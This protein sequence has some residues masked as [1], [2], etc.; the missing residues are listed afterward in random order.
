MPRKPPPT[1]YT[2]FNLDERGEVKSANFIVFTDGG[3]YTIA[4]DGGWDDPGFEG[5]RAQRAYE[6]AHFPGAK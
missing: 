5:E 1:I 2:Q 6:L 3:G 4:I